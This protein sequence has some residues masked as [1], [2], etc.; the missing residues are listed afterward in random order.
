MS[1]AWGRQWC[2]CML[3]VAS[4]PGNLCRQWSHNM[5]CHAHAGHVI[6]ARLLHCCCPRYR[7]QQADTHTS[8]QLDCPHPA[9]I[10]EALF[11]AQAQVRHCCS[12][13]QP[14]TEKPL[15][16]I[17][18]QVPSN[19]HRQRL[20]TTG[21]HW[22]PHVCQQG[23]VDAC[24]IPAGSVIK[25]ILSC[26]TPGSWPCLSACL[27]GRAAGVRGSAGCDQGA[28]HTGHPAAPRTEPT[29]P[30]AGTLPRSVLGKGSCWAQLCTEQVIQRFGRHNNAYYITLPSCS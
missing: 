8:T 19:R 7:Q 29:A 23:V 3:K 18:G 13:L 16:A 20:G 6:T 1:S 15:L 27:P 10:Q 2:W 25:H 9:A 5:I 30:W 26:T 4:S 17:F 11:G 14:A 28:G 22:Q 21:P 12:H 24:L